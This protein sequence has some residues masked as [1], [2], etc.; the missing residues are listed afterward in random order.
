MAAPNAARRRQLAKEG[1]ANADGSYPTD[2]KGRAVAAK[3]RATAAE[4]DGRISKELER[5][6]DARANRTLGKSGKGGKGK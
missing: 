3:A 5:R 2:T 6:I 4:R 1:K